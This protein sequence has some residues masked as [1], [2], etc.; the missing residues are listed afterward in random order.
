M[1][2][3]FSAQDGRNLFIRRHVAGKLAK[4]D[5]RPAVIVHRIFGIDCLRSKIPAAGTPT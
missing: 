5:V 4:L 3:F 2:G 1:Q